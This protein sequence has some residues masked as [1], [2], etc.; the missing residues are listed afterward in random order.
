MKT[1]VHE[2]SYGARV[3][4]APE[5]GC[6]L[7]SWVVGGRELLFR[8]EGFGEKAGGNPILYP[9]VG[10]TWAKGRDGKPEADKYRVHGKSGE[11]R[12]PCHGVAAQ[13]RWDKLA[14]RRGDG[15]VQVEYAFSLSAAARA[16]NY[17]FDLA[18]SLRYTLEAAAVG[19]EASFRN[20]G[21]GPAPFAFG[22][23]PYFR[24][25][26]RDAAKVR[27]PCAKRVLL[28][29]ELLIPVGEEALASPLLEF[30]RG[31]TYDLAFGGMTGRRASV[32]EAAPGMDIHV[33]F[34]GNIE[35]F[36][37]YSGAGSSCVCL[38]PW[39]KGLGAYGKLE[40]EGWAESGTIPVLRPRE[41]KTISFKYSIERR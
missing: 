24:V 27:L 14:E 41:T 29:P 20:D 37:V 38:E 16:A 17:P 10:R 4:I 28:D 25:A 8:P 9:A 30:E 26:D 40:N 6:N 5:L 18:F 39:T 1:D 23:H 7:F 3:S 19:I 2:L 35:M 15:S 31:R 34:D 13:G 11:Y 22:C 12:M 33:D 32:L 21:G 36:V